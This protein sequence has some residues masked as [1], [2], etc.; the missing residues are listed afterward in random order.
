MRDAYKLGPFV[1]SVEDSFQWNRQTVQRRHRHY[2]RAL[3]LKAV[4]DVVIRWEIESVGNQFIAFSTPI[5]AR[6]DNGL[7]YRHVLMHHDATFGRSDDGTDKITAGNR[8]HPPALFPRPDS[9]S[10]PCTCE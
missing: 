3:S 7:A 10:G 1:D 9:T 8:H 6:Y 5:E 2:L 4:V